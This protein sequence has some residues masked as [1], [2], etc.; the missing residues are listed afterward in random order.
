MTRGVSKVSI[1]GCAEAGR[2]GIA[3]SPTTPA[4]L[5]VLTGLLPLPLTPTLPLTLSLALLLTAEEEGD[6]HP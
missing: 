5:T 6:L 3:S 1:V 4:A 2:G